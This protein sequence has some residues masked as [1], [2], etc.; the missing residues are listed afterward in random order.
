MIEVGKS[1]DRIMNFSCMHVFAVYCH[2]SKQSLTF[3]VKNEF[4]RGLKDAGHTCEVSD[5]YAMGFNAE[6]NEREYLRD[7]FY[8]QNGAADEDVL[9][10]QK[11]VQRA[12]AIVFIYPVFWTDVPAKLKGWFDRVWTCGFAYGDARSMKQLEYALVI[13]TAGKTI[14]ALEE[15]GE[16][17]AM[18]TVMLGDRIRDRAKRKQLVILG[19]TTRS[20]MAARERKAPQHLKAAYEL[21]LTFQT[22]TMI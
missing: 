13:T 14:E 6:L 10:E 1:Y 15:T 17:H 4:L 18:E 9:C 11:K 2:P 3:E 8:T 20:D 7:G 12:G 5:L 19:G 22:R 21:G 16:A